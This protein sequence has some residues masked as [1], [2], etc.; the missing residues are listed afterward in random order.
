[1]DAFKFHPGVYRQAAGI[2]GL[3]VGQ[4]LMVSVN[5]FDVLCE[6]ACGYRDALVNRERLPY[7]DT[8]YQ[9]NV[10][11]SNFTELART[12]A[13]FRPMPDARGLWQIGTDDSHNLFF[14]KSR[15]VN[16]KHLIV[17]AVFRAMVNGHQP[18]VSLAFEHTPD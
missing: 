10:T 17:P 11:V 18:D 8:R 5:S 16:D 9:P 6:Q 3:E 13:P 1:V 12:T 15:A 4:C 14:R 2:L 7:E